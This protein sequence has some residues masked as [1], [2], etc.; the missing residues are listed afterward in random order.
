M[1]A[2]PSRYVLVLTLALAL[3]LAGCAS[4]GGSSTRNPGS[5]SNRIVRADLDALE[6]TLDVY[7]AIERLRPR[8]LQTRGRVGSRPV[9]YVSGSRRGDLDDLK[10][11]QAAEVEQMEYMSPSDATTRF[12][13]GHSGGAILVT[14]RRR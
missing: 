6:G 3:G 9:L 10:S 8:W 1:R 5:S 12:G 14:N 2:N 4:S 7:Q 13:T 11:M